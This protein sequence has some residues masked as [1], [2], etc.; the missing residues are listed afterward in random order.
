MRDYYNMHP[1]ASR[2][3]STTQV[4]SIVNRQLISELASR[5]ALIIDIVKILQDSNPQLLI[6]HQEIISKIKGFYNENQE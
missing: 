1:R 4:I 5:D 3:T 6:K 2:G